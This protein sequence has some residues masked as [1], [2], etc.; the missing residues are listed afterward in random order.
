MMTWMVLTEGMSGICMITRTNRNLCSCLEN[1]INVFE[2]C[3]SYTW[4][5]TL[6][7]NWHS[8]FG[9]YSAQLTTIRSQ[10]VVKQDSMLVAQV[11][12][13]ALIRDVL[14]AIGCCL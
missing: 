5:K 4:P 9:N 11:N 7:A 13:L 12:Y 14:K 10:C 2:R 3:C 6:A 1:L 8:V